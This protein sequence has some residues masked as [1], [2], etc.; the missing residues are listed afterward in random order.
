MN[1]IYELENYI[2]S[3][4]N[5]I[6]YYTDNIYNYLSR[7]HTIIET[8]EHITDE[9]WKEIDEAISNISYYVEK[10]EKL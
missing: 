3:L 2:D 6:R 7:L 9:E 10:I 5:D 1:R 4:K 8:N